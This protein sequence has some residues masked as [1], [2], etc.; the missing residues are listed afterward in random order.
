ME[1]SRGTTDAL[2]PKQDV[3]NDEQVEVDSSELNL[4]HFT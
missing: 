3:E 4:T 1:L 2:F